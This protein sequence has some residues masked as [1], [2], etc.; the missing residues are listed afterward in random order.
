[1]IG[2]S[3]LP[4]FSWNCV[5]SLLHSS[6]CEKKSRSSTVLKTR[7]IQSCLR[8]SIRLALQPESAPSPSVEDV[9]L[10]PNSAASRASPAPSHSHLHSL[11]QVLCITTSDLRSTTQ[12]FSQPYDLPLGGALFLDSFCELDRLCMSVNRHCSVS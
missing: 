2:F 8:Q 10:G 9:L 3:D 11:S 5:V 1:M 4:R 7:M 12:L 6:W